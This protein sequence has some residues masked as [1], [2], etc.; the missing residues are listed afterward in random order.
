MRAGR[1]P[2][3]ENAADGITKKPLVLGGGGRSAAGDLPVLVGDDLWRY[4]WEGR[5]QLHGFNPYQ[6]APD[7]PALVPLRDAEWNRISHL[8][9]PAIYPPL[10]EMTF[11]AL[12][13]LRTPVIGYKILFGL[14]DLGVVF[15][16]VA[17]L[18]AGRGRRTAP[19]GTRGIRWW[20]TR[21]RG[22]RISTG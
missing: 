7:A 14:M 19:R 5:I 20:S 13:S 18:R 10:T 12:A 21:R 1:R 16:C 2:L 17:S 6:L 15:C 4:R 9:F 11:A 22:R 8:N 3:P